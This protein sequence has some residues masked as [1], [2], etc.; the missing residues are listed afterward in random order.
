MDELY[1]SKK[2]FNQKKDSGKFGP[3][4]IPK[5]ARWEDANT[6]AVVLNRPIS[7]IY[8]MTQDKAISRPR[9]KP[10]INL[11]RRNEVNIVLITRRMVTEPTSVR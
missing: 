5:R 8:A 10:E 1:Y 2:K 3:E 4:R 9:L 11:N 7:Y 6:N